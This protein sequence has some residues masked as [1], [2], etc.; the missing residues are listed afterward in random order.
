VKI[1]VRTAIQFP[2]YDHSGPDQSPLDALIAFQK[3]VAPGG[4]SLNERLDKI[5]L[6]GRE[7]TG[8]RRYG[9]RAYDDILKVVE[10]NGQVT[11]PVS[12]EHRF[13]PRRIVVGLAVLIALATL[14][15]AILA[16][17]NS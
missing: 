4:M 15:L 5:V 3:P 12:A 2:E 14:A 8:H 1:T 6:F 17:A 9:G 10:N 16:K 7:L 11:L 13:S